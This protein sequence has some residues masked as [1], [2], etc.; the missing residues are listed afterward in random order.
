MHSCYTSWQSVKTA[1]KTI[2]RKKIS[3][4]TQVSVVK[5]PQVL[6]IQQTEKIEQDDSF[7]SQ[8]YELKYRISELQAQLLTE[9]LRP[10]IPLDKYSVAQPDHQYYISSV[11]F[12]SSQLTLFNETMDGKCNRYKL[13]VR[14]YSD[15]P[16]S[17]I[18]FEV[19]RRLG[20]VICKSRYKAHRNDLKPFL[21]DNVIPPIIADHDDTDLRQFLT[22]YKLLHAKPIALVKYKREAYES[23]AKNRVRI[24][25]DRCLSC[26][27]TNEPII[28][29]NGPGWQDVKAN[30]VVLEIKFTSNYP[31]WLSNMV[32]MFNLNISSMSKYCSSV[33]T[34]PAYSWVN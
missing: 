27:M 10:I 34:L 8:R 32:R 5:A 26:Q 16:E 9:Y 1:M 20:E 22:Y 19:K 31:S 14:A 18:F 12:D 7:L 15:D 23:T 25:F 29:I 13:R 11:Y 30:F 33:R 17:P 21:V 4:S 24:T 3:H 28:K 6:A 2:P